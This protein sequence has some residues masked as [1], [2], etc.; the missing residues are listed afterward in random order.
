MAKPDICYPGMDGHAEFGVGAPAWTCLLKLIGG[1]ISSGGRGA[2]LASVTTEPLFSSIALWDP[3]Y[4]GPLQEQ[5][6][7]LKHEA[8]LDSYRPHFHCQF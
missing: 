4:L 7:A 5:P 2:F 6:K 3:E 8:S 1:R